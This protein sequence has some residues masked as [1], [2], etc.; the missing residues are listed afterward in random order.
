MLSDRQL[1]SG[2]EEITAR[3]EPGRERK[4]ALGIY[5]TPQQAADILARWAIRSSND[6]VLEPSFGGCSMLSAAVTAFSTLGNPNPAQQL[7]GYDIDS[8]AFDYLSQ[9]GIDND[10]GH[11]RREDFLNSTA[12]DLKVDAVLANPPF[13]S[14]Q[15]LKPEQRQRTD[16][17]RM[18]YLPTL[19][20]KASLWVY[21]LLH[22]MTFLRIGGRMAFVL[23][24]AIGTAD[25]AKEV[26][27][28]L[29]SK[30][31]KVELFHVA[32][33]LFIQTGADERVS[34]LL[35]DGYTPGGLTPPS[36]TRCIDVHSVRELES[37]DDEA[38]KKFNVP[39]MHEIRELASQ[40]LS[41]LEGTVFRVIGDIAKVQIGEVVGDIKF[42]VRPKQEWEQQGIHQKYLLPLLTRSSQV[43][44]LRTNTYE[45]DD[46]IPRLLRPDHDFKEAAIKNYLSKYNKEKRNLNKTFAK[47]DAWFHCSYNTEADAFIGSMN[48]EIARIVGNGAK[49]SAS[50]AFYKIQVHSSIDYAKW[51]PAISLTTPTRLSAEILGRVRGSGGIKLEP[52]DVKKMVIPKQL[53][54][55][56]PDEFEEFHL[57]LDRLVSEGKIEKATHLADTYIFSSTGLLNQEILARMQSMQ[58][59]LTN[60]RLGRSVKND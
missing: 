31:C 55:L 37:H 49:I 7:F 45:I 15:R 60:Y 56:S 9:M 53:P 29:E 4:R 34:I 27:A 38:D 44:S 14:H 2:N 39:R 19:H 30:F 47:R 36:I 23:P 3:T 48:H 18:K 51:L 58:R 54:E 59:C 33:Q 17:L 46:N 26:V 5:Y 20:R 1:T 52:K 21:F 8:I 24:N 35:L 57:Q 10:A 50:N 32:E 6:L 40:E 11:F 12:S 41:S 43:P 13:V 28:F 25:Y 42:F 16:Q 22:A